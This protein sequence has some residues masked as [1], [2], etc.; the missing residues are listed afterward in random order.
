MEPRV[1]NSK[2]KLTTQ[3]IMNSD[4]SSSLRIISP[5]QQSQESLSE[6]ST[7]KE[8]PKRLIQSDP[9]T[10]NRRRMFS[11][12]E[13]E[14]LLIFIIQN[15][16]RKY[17]NASPYL[18][19]EAPNSISAQFVNVYKAPSTTLCEA[20]TTDQA[21][22]ASVDQANFNDRSEEASASCEGDGVTTSRPL[23]ENETYGCGLLV[24]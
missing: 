8:E 6:E 3:R 18:K 9:P 11:E 24:R 12:N 17:L 13:N 23:V 4:W 19:K 21:R 22:R 10:R 15:I 14:G 16:K 5:A 7:C 20:S 2:T 1:S